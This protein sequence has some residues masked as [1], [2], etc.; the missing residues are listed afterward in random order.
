MQD[1]FDVREIWKANLTFST[2][3]RLFP[4]KSVSPK[5]C[6]VLF[7]SQRCTENK[8][9]NLKLCY[10]ARLSL[11]TSSNP[12]LSGPASPC[13]SCLS[14]GSGS[15]VGSAWEVILFPPNTLASVEPFYC[16]VSFTLCLFN[17]HTSCLFSCYWSEN[18]G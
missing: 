13:C 3:K 1:I 12:F 2:R 14:A 4:H 16:C 10:K 6:W 7:S 5:K 17:T 15:V 11:K 8:H 18:E 9:P